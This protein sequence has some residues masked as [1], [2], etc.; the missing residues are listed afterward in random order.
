MTPDFLRWKD[1]AM[2]EGTPEY[3]SRA[4]KR[5]TAKKEPKEK[6]TSGQ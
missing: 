5:T 3:I 6:V 4:L 1:H 2:V